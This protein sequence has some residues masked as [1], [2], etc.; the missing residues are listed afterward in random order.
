MMIMIKNTQDYDISLH[1]KV[2]FW[3]IKT[4]GKK[5]QFIQPCYHIVNIWV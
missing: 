2:M 4:N 1:Y 3:C 5:P